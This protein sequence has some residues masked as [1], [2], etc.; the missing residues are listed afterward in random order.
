MDSPQGTLS[1]Q[2]IFRIM[3]NALVFTTPALLVG[4]TALQGG[5]SPTI[6]IG[7]FAQAF[8]GIIIDALRKLS[9]GNKT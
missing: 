8:I 4:L 1:K 2:D 6:A 9:D 5:V 7:M 3:T